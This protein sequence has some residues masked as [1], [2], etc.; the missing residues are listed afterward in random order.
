[1]GRWGFLKRSGFARRSLPSNRYPRLCLPQLTPLG[2]FTLGTVVLLATATL[3]FATGIEFRVFL[4]YSLAIAIYTW[5][6]GK[7]VAVLAVAVS[8]V[9]WLGNEY[10]GGRQYTRPIAWVWNTTITMAAFSVFAV[11]T[12][13]LRLYLETLHRLVNTD[14][15]TSL[16]NRRAFIRILDRTIVRARSRSQSTSV[17]FLDIDRF[18]SVNDG[19]GHAAGDRVLRELAQALRHSVRRSDFTARMGGDEFAILMPNTSSDQARRIA[20]QIARI[21]AE[22]MQG[23][24]DQP[25]LSIGVVTFPSRLRWDADHALR[26]ADEQM[27]LAKRGG[28]DRIVAR[29]LTSES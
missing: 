28:R 15:L 5:Y 23:R 8:A 22:R 20:G 21:F 6:L 2:A 11:L 16:H 24:P 13:W 17:M 27:Y 4:F 1:M 12:Y 7:R 19:E 26:V 29:D 10:L 9:C 18:K 25:T 14:D 3:D